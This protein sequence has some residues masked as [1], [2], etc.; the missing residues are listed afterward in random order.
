MVDRFFEIQRKQKRKALV[1]KQRR[2]NLNRMKEEKLF[3]KRTEVSIKSI[4]FGS[5]TLLIF[6]SKDC[7]KNKGSL[8][9]STSQKYSKCLQTLPKSTFCKPFI[10]KPFFKIPEFK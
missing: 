3:V 2:E 10:S 9:K 7:F 5:I 8:F 4:L 6:Y 1:E